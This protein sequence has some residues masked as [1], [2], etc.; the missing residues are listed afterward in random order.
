[1]TRRLSLSTR[2]IVALAL[3]AVLGGLAGCAWFWLPVDVPGTGETVESSLDRD[4][5]PDVSAD[6]VAALVAGNTAFAFDLFHELVADGNLFYSPFSISAAL[7]MTYAG[8]AGD[9]KAQM[10][11][12][13]HFDVDPSE[14]HSAFNVLDLELNSRSTIEPPYEGEGFDLSVVNAAWGQRGHTFLRAYLDVLAV[15]YGAGLRLLDFEGDPDGSR[16]TINDWVCQETNDKILDLLPPGSIDTATRLVLTNAVY[17]NAPWLDPFD[18]GQ[19][20]TGAFKPLHGDTVYVPMMRQQLRAD[21]A[22]WDGG[23][24]VELPYNG[25]TLSMILLVPDRGTFEAFEAEVDAIEYES[26]IS[27]LESRPVT[28]QLPRFKAGYEASLAEPLGALGMVDPFIFGAADFSGIDGTSTLFI[29]DVVH[30]AWVSVD[31]TGTEAAAAT[32][33]IMPGGGGGEPVTLTIDRP[34]LFVI[35]DIPTNTILFLG[36]IVEIAD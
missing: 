32:A 27:A 11:S 16:E 6:D 35:R 34:F 26:I 18:P 7:A 31:E 15:N 2:V 24:A 25:N 5:D 19:T 13:L 17:F 36:R 20:R 14:P 23:Q 8:A 10:A 9:T 28:L 12:A 3:M 21:Y 1:M 29:S 4:L 30:K 33:V 22:T